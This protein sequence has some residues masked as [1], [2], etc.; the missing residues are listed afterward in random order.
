[1]KNSV[2]GIDVKQAEK[3]SQI[4]HM[5]DAIKNTIK[6]MINVE[7]IILKMTEAKDNNKI[8]FSYIKKL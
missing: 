8:V 6:L 3:K 5:F 1:M 4:S 2:S 7:A